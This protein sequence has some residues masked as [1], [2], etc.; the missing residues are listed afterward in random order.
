MDERYQTGVSRNW[1]AA[2]VGRQRHRTWGKGRGHAPRRLL[3]Y[4]HGCVL[5]HRVIRLIVASL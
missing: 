2:V 4:I 3:I 5:S 1:A